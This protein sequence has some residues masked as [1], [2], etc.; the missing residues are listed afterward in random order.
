MHLF[1]MKLRWFAV[2]GILTVVATACLPAFPGGAALTVKPSSATQVNLI[3]NPATDSDPG[4]GIADYAIYVNNVYSAYV[5]APATNCTLVGLQPS[6]SYNFLVTAVGLDGEW[7]GNIGGALQSLGRLSA[8]YTTPAGSPSGANLGCANPNQ[9]APDSDGDR[10]PDWAE[11]NTGTYVNPGNA[12]TNPANPD[13]DGDGISDGDETLGTLGGLPLPVMGAKPLRKSIFVEADWYDTTYA[14]GYSYSQRPTDP[15]INRLKSAFST[16]AV[17]NPDG[18]T[19]VD[20]IVD[21]GQGGNFLG[22]NKVAGDGVIAG[23]VNNPNDTTFDAVKAANFNAGRNGYFHYVLMAATWGGT[24]SSGVA[25]L[26]GDDF[27]VSLPDCYSLSTT[28]GAS[29]AEQIGNTIMHE[30]GHNLNLHHGGSNDVNYKPNFNSIM[31][32]RF[33]G[34]GIDTTCDA[35]GDHALSYSSGTRASLNEAALNE[36]TGV[37]G[38]GFPIDWNKSGTLT[39]S[40]AVDLNQ[41]QVYDSYSDYNDWSHISFGGLTNADGLAAQPTWVVEQPAVPR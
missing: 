8:D 21:Y 32:Y 5:Y 20:L 24:S 7:S 41:N 23:E 36:L 10:L 22:G 35:N 28:N 30:L 18:S 26:P 16:A 2:A 37:C 6:T 1:G 25:E 38:S 3:W 4:D 14:C 29:H 27:I 31:N 11:T 17:A 13:T 33:Q 40:V 39:S 34:D 19:G 12:G 9:G 15:E